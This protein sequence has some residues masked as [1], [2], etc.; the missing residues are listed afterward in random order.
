MIELR[1]PLTLLLAIATISGCTETSMEDATGKAQLR[2]INGIANVA[3]V[4][5]RI[6]Q[7]ELSSLQYKGTS[8]SQ[9]F[10][11]LSYQFNF[12]LPVPPESPSRLASRILDVIEDMEYTFVLAGTF[13]NPEV[14]LWER[15]EATWEGTET[16]FDVGAGH[17]NTTLGEIDIYVAPPGTAP[18]LGNAIGSVNFGERTADSQLAAGDYTFILTAKDDPATILYESAAITLAGAD[19][20]T[21]V[22]FDAD[23]SITGPLSVR[24]IDLDGNGVELPD[25][26]FPPTVQFVH[27]AFGSGNIDVVADGDFTNPLLTDVPF[28]SVTADVNIVPGPVTYSFTP[29]ASTTP[30]VE[31]DLAVPVGTRTLSVLLGEAGNLAI[32]NLASERRGF[33]T[34]SRYRFINASAN[35][36]AVDLYFVNTGDAIDDRLPNVF[37]VGL[38]GATDVSLQIAQEFD[39]YVTTSA[40]QTVLAGPETVTLDVNQVTE[41]VLLDTAD[42]NQSELLIFNNAG[43]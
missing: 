6:E 31:G 30:L 4:Q 11:N 37:G 3:D 8:G 41:F 32:L 40:T 25:V 16:V 34:V 27:A 35:A 24:L 33:S 10:D 2:A 15:P 38:G 22:A 20:Y 23:P 39:L 13:S 1:R 36:E 17:T 19:S 9:E 21:A 12:D 5:F 26:N 18:V 29:P 28:G 42:P 7:L 43:P 14:F